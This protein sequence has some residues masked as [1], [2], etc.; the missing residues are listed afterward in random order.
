VGSNAT[1]GTGARIRQWRDLLATGN[2][3][4]FTDVVL[5]TGVGSTFRNDHG[6]VMDGMATALL[7]RNHPAS[8]LAQLDAILDYPPILENALRVQAPSLVMYG[9]EDELVPK[10]DARE[11]ADTLNADWLPIPDAGHSLP[12]EAPG[13][14]TDA[15]MKFLSGAAD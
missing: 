11:L 12:V 8:L 1:S 13:R 5:N 7:K 4:S 6:T 10:S 3:T 14:F 15:A 9:E 2:L